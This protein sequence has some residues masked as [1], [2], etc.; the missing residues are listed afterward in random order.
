MDFTEETAGA[1]HELTHEVSALRMCLDAKLDSL[2]RHQAH[3]KPEELAAFWKR[4]ET[5]FIKSIWVG[6][7]KPVVIFGILFGIN[8]KALSVLCNKIAVD[9]SVS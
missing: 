7:K 3:V 4:L 6:G 1:L 8:P 5:V 9:V 2:T